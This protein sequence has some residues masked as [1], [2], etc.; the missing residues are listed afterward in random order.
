MSSTGGS[1]SVLAP[2]RHLGLELLFE[3]LTQ[4]SFPK[5]AFAR[6]RAKLLSLID[7][8]EQQPRNKT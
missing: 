6:E 4:A 5:D 3:C 1:V 8:S 2:H 7:E